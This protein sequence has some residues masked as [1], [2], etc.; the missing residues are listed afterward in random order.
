MEFRRKRPVMVAMDLVRFAALLSIPVA[1]ALGRL[2]FVQLVVVS[3]IVGAAKNAFR[4]ASGAYV[5]ELVAPED[6]LVANGRFESTTWSA[7]AVGPPLG[8]ASRSACSDP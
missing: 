2:T 4:A 8:G 1:Y 6:L 3:V 7:T 5:K